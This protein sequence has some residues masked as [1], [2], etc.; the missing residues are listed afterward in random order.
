MKAIGFP[1]WKT[2]YRRFFG[3]SFGVLYPQAFH[4]PRLTLPAWNA[5]VLSRSICY[6]EP[7]YPFPSFSPFCRLSLSEPQ[8]LAYT[9]PGHRRQGCPPGSFYKSQTEPFLLPS[10]TASPPS[11]LFISVN[12]WIR[13]LY[14]IMDSSF[15]FTTSNFN[16]YRY[17]HFAL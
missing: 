13:N 5:G 8:T 4:G 6:L 16:D 9:G 12:A 15:P 11:V 2:A 14:F 7:R 1:S 10:K 17:S 3:Y